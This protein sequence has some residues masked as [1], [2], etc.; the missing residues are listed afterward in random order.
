M[1]HPQG[2]CWSFHKKTLDR[3][4]LRSFQYQYSWIQEELLLGWVKLSS[5]QGQGTWHWRS[6]CH[7]FQERPFLSLVHLTVKNTVLFFLI[8][9]SDP[10]LSTVIFGQI[11]N[12]KVIQ[13]WHLRENKGREKC[14]VSFVDAQGD[15][16]FL[17]TGSRSQKW[18]LEPENLVTSSGN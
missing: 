8:I 13:F 4:S 15:G 6:S 5:F 17:E 9:G 2:S 10:F 11:T 7:C 1:I 16:Q 12:E 18:C 14:R 3:I